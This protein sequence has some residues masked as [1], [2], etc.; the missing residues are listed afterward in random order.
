VTDWLSVATGRMRLKGAA[1]DVMVDDVVALPYVV[2]ITWPALLAARPSA[3][4]ALPTL[5]A[6]GTL[7]QTGGMYC[8]GA[9]GRAKTTQG[10]T[11]AGFGSLYSLPFTLREVPT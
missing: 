10:Q 8:R 2:P 9:V 4:P 6:S 7:P 5:E 11:D 1:S 3:F